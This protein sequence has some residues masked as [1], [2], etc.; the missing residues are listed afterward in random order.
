[1]F[2][3]PF[4]PIFG[5]KPDVFFGRDKILELFELAM[6]ERG[7]DERLM[8]IT[9]TRG[10]GKT[11]LLE[12]MSIR[13]MKKRKVIDLGPDDTVEQFI[14]ELCGYDEVV[15][16]VSPQANLNI[17]GVGGG[18]SGGSISKAKHIGREKLQPLLLDFCSKNKQG[19]LVTID[20]IQKVSLEDVSSICNA[21]QMASRKGYDIMFA[22]AG[23]PYS[24]D[25]IVQHT[26]CSYLRRSVH[27]EIGLFTWDEASD[28]LNEMF[29]GIKG[30]QIDQSYLDE[31]N[32]FSYGHP[33][34]MQLLGYHLILCINE[35]KP[36]ARH[37][38]SEVELKKAEQN[39]L[40]AYQH[41]ALKPLLDEF[42]GQE[43]KYLMKMSECLDSNR[44]TATSDIAKALGT[45]QNKLSKV[46]ETLIAHGII[47][48][49]ERGKVMFCVP[50]LAD[51]V[52]QEAVNSSVI[53]VARQ[54]GV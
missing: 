17:L 34:I 31:I 6:F 4:T 52:K 23:L 37:T 18:V 39:T 44:L 10:F 41:R 19:L 26:G 20:E 15:K 13:A 43:R 38:V 5:G 9:G 28:A 24:Y 1:M 42:S 53:S 27:E 46:R 25:K 49:P 8:F 22:A 30:L 11:A 32:K 14:T 21:F 47:A 3:N 16:T 36:K 51:Y 33:Y 35:N 54:R 45:T 29:S 7:S 50:Y 40:L 48:A 2:S 12:Q